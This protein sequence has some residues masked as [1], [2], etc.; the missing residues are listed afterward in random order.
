MECHQC[1]ECFDETDRLS[2]SAKQAFDD[3]LRQC[4]AC[5][6]ELAA[7]SLVDAALSEHTYRGLS[8]G[9]TAQVLAS[10]RQDR[11]RVYSPRLG[12]LVNA[13]YA[14]SAV[15]LVCGFTQFAA[16][17]FLKVMTV[18]GRATGAVVPIQRPDLEWLTGLL[19]TVSPQVG[20]LA[21]TVLTIALAY[22]L[23]TYLDNGRLGYKGN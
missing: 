1:R 11:V 18:F 20:V 4:G 12:T 23:Y 7:D 3:H 21:I 16:S 2:R 17:G 15:V 8:V 14:L 9:F 6:R 13:A 19:S 22:G 5:R 10:Y